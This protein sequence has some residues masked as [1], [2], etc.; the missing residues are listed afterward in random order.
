VKI[1]IDESSRLQS[2]SNVVIVFNLKAECSCQCGVV[3][4]CVFDAVKFDVPLNVHAE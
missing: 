1:E 4:V 3:C 2:S